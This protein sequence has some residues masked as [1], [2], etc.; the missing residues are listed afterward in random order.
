MKSAIRYKGLL[1]IIERFK[2]LLVIQEDRWEMAYIRKPL[3]QSTIYVTMMSFY[4]S[5]CQIG[6]IFIMLQYYTKIFCSKKKKKHQNIYILRDV[7]PWLR[8]SG[9]KYSQC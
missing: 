4:L 8:E 6:F 9:N 1:S 2:I 3:C 5:F 7:H